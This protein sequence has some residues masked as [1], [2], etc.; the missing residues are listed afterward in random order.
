MI[1]RIP[2]LKRD[3]PL[4][5]I[6]GYTFMLLFILGTDKIYSSKKTTLITFNVLSSSR[7]WVDHC[8]GQQIQQMRPSSYVD[9]QVH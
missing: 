1:N 6:Y 3:V 7:S 4:S 5:M 9:V 2:S 8:P